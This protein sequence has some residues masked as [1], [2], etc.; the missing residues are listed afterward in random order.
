MTRWL[1]GS[2][3][4]LPVR[5]SPYQIS[6]HASR[7]R[8]RPPASLFHTLLCTRCS[9]AASPASARRRHGS[10]VPTA[11]APAPTELQ[12]QLHRR[13]PSHPAAAWS[14]TPFPRVAAHAFPNSEQ[15]GTR[16][17]SRGGMF[18]AWP[19]HTS[20][21]S[22][23]CGRRFALSVCACFALLCIRAIL[24]VFTATFVHSPAFAASTSAATY[25]FLDSEREA[26]S[27]FTAAT[28]E[29]KENGGYVIGRWVGAGQ[30]ARDGRG[31]G[32]GGRGG[33][34]A[35]RPR[36]VKGK[37]MEGSRRA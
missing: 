30:G 26:T 35:S 4:A 14:F 23:P 29:R 5:S 2:A 31:G 7:P 3:R 1:V 34:D 22:H 18:K 8:H 15:D 12:L 24:V 16:R 21:G 25:S 36:P 27:R 19:L 37:G 10:P 9:G 17:C 20:V 33:A 13:C 6:V 32:A 28:C 11:A